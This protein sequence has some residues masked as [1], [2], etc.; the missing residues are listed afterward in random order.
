MVKEVDA[1]SGSAVRAVEV[2]MEQELDPS[3]PC[4]QHLLSAILA[5]EPSECLIS[6]ARF[7]FASFVFVF[8]AL[9]E[10]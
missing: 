1:S 7:L 8:P 5:M 6:H 10:V 9:V 4:C 3:V 2:T